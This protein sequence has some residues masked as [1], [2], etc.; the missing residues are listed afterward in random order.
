MGQPGRPS[1]PPSVLSPPDPPSPEFPTLDPSLPEP[2]PPGPWPPDL[3]PTVSS[4]VGSSGADVVGGEGSTDV[5]E[6]L[7]VPA[8]AVA[9]TSPAQPASSAAASAE[10]ASADPRPMMDGRRKPEGS[11]G[12]PG[13]V[14]SPGGIEDLRRPAP[15]HPGA[16]RSAGY[17]DVLS[18]GAPALLAALAGVAA[19]RGTAGTPRFARMTFSLDFGPP[20]IPRAA[21]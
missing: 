11:R 17:S 16:S 9:A 15:R 3:W 6:G 19:A 14:A 13:V 2:W 4:S 10:H 12:C 20:G 5:V 21:D 1:V 8:D 18:D 7:P